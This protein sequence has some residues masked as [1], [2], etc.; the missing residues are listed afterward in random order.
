MT[1][2]SRL[3][4]ASLFVVPSTVRAQ[5]HAQMGWRVAVVGGV[6]VPVGEFARG[7]EDVGFGW[8]AFLG[9]RFKS[10]PVVIGIEG[11][12]YEYGRE[13]FDSWAYG[14]GNTEGS[15]YRTVNDMRSG[16]VVLKVEQDFG[17][18]TPYAE[19]LVGLKE[20]RT[21]TEL[22]GDSDRSID[23]WSNIRDTAIS[24]GTGIG[25]G[26]GTR[27]AGVNARVQFGARYMLGGA[28]TYIKPLTITR[29]GGSSAFKPSRSRTD[30]IMSFFGFSVDY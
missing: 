13:T 27:V 16:H 17:R 20:L 9:Y 1:T 4:I 22:L 5:T 28:A 18:I 15:R 21:K 8:S 29:V 25:L 7:L 19:G 2:L 3:L 6:M 23:R 24:Y 11:S 30:T 14:L 10:T 12:A 26:I